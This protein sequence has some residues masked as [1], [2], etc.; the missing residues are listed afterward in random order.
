[1]GRKEDNIAKAQKLM[2]KPKFIRC[3]DIAAH[4]DHGK[5]TLTDNL[6]AGAGMMSDELAGK[7]LVMDFD[8]QGK[9]LTYDIGACV[10]FAEANGFKGIYS[11]EQW[12][13]KPI[14]LD[15]VAA[16]RRIIEEIVK[17]I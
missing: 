8:E 6:I 17:N 11:A 9:H 1:M 3:I 10:R 7:Q 5:T 14:P 13:P 16:A 12:S 15:P 2:D 4:I